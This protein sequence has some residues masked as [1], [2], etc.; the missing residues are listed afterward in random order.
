MIEAS[1]TTGYLQLDPSIPRSKLGKRFVIEGP[2]ATGKSEQAIR[3]DQRLRKLGMQT[4]LVLND[5]SKMLE[6]IQEPGGVPIANE[7]RKIIKNGAL[8]RDPWTNVLLF[9]AARRLNW[10][11]A[12]KPALES[13]IHVVSARNW[14]STVTYQG[15]GEGIPFGQIKQ[16]TVEDVGEDYIRP[17][18][19]V[20]LNVSDELA[21][22]SL[23]AQRGRLENPDTFESKSSDFQERMKKGYLDYA[24]MRGRK[25]IPVNVWPGM[26]IEDINHSKQEVEDRIWEEVEQVL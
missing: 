24:Q 25:V 21:R 26:T 12:I 9:T 16:R 6:P 20:I 7:L 1:S 11:Q 3:L 19:E 2:D 14:V 4:L 22:K 10:L 8:E 13:G 5:D 17:E 18:L 23:I 15:Y